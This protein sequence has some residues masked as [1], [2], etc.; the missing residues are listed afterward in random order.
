M[1]GS[2]TLW[3]ADLH[4]AFSKAFQGASQA[5]IAMTGNIVTPL[6]MPSLGGLGNRFG[7]AHHYRLQS[8]LSSQPL[9][10]AKCAA[11]SGLPHG[12]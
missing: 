12:P 3:S 7:K 8:L 2:V 6:H 4:T 1:H 10:H 9:M 11:L 5:S